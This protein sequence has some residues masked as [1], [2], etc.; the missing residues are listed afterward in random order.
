M[1]QAGTVFQLRGW[2][3]AFP[4]SFRSNPFLSAYKKQV[5]LLGLK[6]WDNARNSPVRFP[7]LLLQLAPLD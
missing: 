1:E 4:L 7:S 3:S 5:N 2:N 6:L